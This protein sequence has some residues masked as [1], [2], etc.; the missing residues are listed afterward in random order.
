MGERE[1]QPAR[2]A[3]N[4]HV[5][6][7]VSLTYIPILMTQFTFPFNMTRIGRIAYTRHIIETVMLNRVS[8]KVTSDHTMYAAGKYFDFDRAKILFFSLTEGGV[9]TLRPI[10]VCS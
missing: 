2:P 7:R 5:L 8:A 3:K 10:S 6:I 4:C 9:P 1:S